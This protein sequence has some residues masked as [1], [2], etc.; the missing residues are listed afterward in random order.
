VLRR[1][2][3]SKVLTKE[4]LQQLMRDQREVFLEALSSGSTGTGGAGGTMTAAKAKRLRKQVTDM[5]AK[6]ARKRPGGG[7]LF[8]SVRKKPKPGAF[9]KFCRWCKRA[10]R[11]SAMHS[12]NSDDCRKKPPGQ[13]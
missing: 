5:Q 11:L 10:E 7:G 8:T 2:K 9:D 13:K 1:N 3:V 12:H 6:L 4:K